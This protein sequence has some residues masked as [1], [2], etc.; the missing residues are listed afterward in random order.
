MV[1]LLPRSTPHI[2]NRSAVE[3]KGN[4]MHRRATLLLVC[5][6][7]LFST[8]GVMI[9]LSTLD[10]L[11]LAGGRSAISAVVLWIALRRLNFTWSRPQIAGALSYVVMVITFIGANQWTSAANAILLQFTAP[12]YVAVLGYWLLKERPRLLDWLSMAAIV[13]GMIFFFSDKLSPTGMIGNLLAIV[14]GVALAFFTI[15]MRMQRDGS[16]L[17]TVLLGNIIAGA[18]GLPFLAMGAKA[19]LPVDWGV[20]LFLGI[21]QLGLPFLLYTRAIRHLEAIEAILIQTLEPIVNPVWVFLFIGE[22]PSRLALLGGAVVVLAVTL[23]A[24][25]GIWTHAQESRSV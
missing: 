5:T 12:L 18:I 24:V 1:R 14:A 23:R 16:S 2:S 22:K 6:V 21:F 10:T 17:E 7:L 15:F 11:A 19:A 13:V 25:A 4:A 9:K 3:K 8:S 20:L